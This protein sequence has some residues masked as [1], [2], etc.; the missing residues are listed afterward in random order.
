MGPEL[1]EIHNNPTSTAVNEGNFTP[2]LFLHDQQKSIAIRPEG[3][4]SS[5]V[6][7]ESPLESNMVAGASSADDNGAEPSEQ[8]N[9]SATDR[10]SRREKK[11]QERWSISTKTD[12]N[13]PEQAAA[14]PLL[15]VE[16]P[17]IAVLKR[18]C[19]PSAATTVKETNETSDSSTPT[20]VEV[21]FQ[22]RIS[23]EGRRQQTISK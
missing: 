22:N 2:S 10:M 14:K 4:P 3:P 12:K 8:A 9:V 15:T 18:K 5:N 13:D 7:A 20:K 6:E 1:E 17:P 16:F 19:S 11:M 21:S 23:I